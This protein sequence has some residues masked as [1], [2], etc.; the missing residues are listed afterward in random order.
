MKFQFE[1][2]SH[3]LSMPGKSIDHG[4]FVWASYAITVVVII[5]LVYFNRKRKRNIVKK[6]QLAQM[7]REQLQEEENAP[8][9]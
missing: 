9:T 4:P 5:G 2:L 1:D 3:F 6:I 7:H 8:T